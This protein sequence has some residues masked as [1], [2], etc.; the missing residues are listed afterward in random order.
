[1]RI[2]FVLFSAFTFIPSLFPAEIS[3]Y[4]NIFD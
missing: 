4:I 2:V 1:L 3:N